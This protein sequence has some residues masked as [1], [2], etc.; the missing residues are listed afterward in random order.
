MQDGTAHL[1]AI[2]RQARPAGGEAEGCARAYAA[3]ILG[4][5]GFRVREEPF[6]YSA[7]P[8]RYATPIGGALG[9]AAVLAGAATGLQAEIRWV[10]GAVLV[11]GLAITAL[12]ARAMLGDAVLDLPV[13]RSRAV[14]LVATSRACEGG[15][16][17]VWLV[18]HTDSKS[19]PVP[20]AARVAGVALLSLGAIVALVI[21]ALQL[22]GSASRTGWWAAIV[23]ALAGAPA[24][25]ASVVGDDSDGAVDN[26]SGVA[27]VLLAA[28]RVPPGVAFGV[29]LPS[30]E[31]LG[32]A[33]T[34]AFARRMGAPCIALNCD[35]VDDEGAMTIMYSGRAP[36]ALVEV[37]RGASPVPVAVRRMPPGLLTDSVALADH[38][39]RALTLS[40][41]SWATLG[42]VHTRHDSLDHLT[43]RGIADA[44]T[45]LANAVEALA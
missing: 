21:A 24:V 5:A 20:S 7:L 16:P 6:T 27:T 33:G 15:A 31:E 34:R 17:A 26:A 3:G 9:A 23:L 41:G 32:M 14:N 37:M 42:R 36:A 43:G 28:T 8:G 38:G 1:N 35:G 45:L 12:F 29:L 30:A 2:A 11:A 4:G 18:A 13:L 39:W 22:A 44:A 25:I 19:Q 10:A 40:R